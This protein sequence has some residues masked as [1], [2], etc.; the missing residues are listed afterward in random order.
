M[1][2]LMRDSPHPTAGDCGCHADAVTHDFRQTPSRRSGIAVT[3]EKFLS[4]DERVL[5]QLLVVGDGN[6]RSLDVRS[7]FVLKITDE[8]VTAVSGFLSDTVAYEAYLA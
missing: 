6:G 4:G 2:L 7:A 3:V 1:S 5:V 8:K